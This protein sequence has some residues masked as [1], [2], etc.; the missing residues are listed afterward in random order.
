M[1]TLRDGVAC[2]L[3]ASAVPFAMAGDVVLAI[4]LLAA[5]GVACVLAVV[6]FNEGSKE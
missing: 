5:A 2:G 1:S 4:G 3:L 6:D